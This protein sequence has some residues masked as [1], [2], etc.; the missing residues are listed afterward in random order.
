MYVLNAI[1]YVLNAI[2]YVLNAIA[3]GQLR[4]MAHFALSPLLRHCPPE[5]FS[6]AMSTE[7]ADL[8]ARVNGYA[9]SRWQQI[10]QSRATNDDHEIEQERALR[11]MTR[12][13]LTMASSMFGPPPNEGHNVCRAQH[14]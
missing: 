11:D 12:A 2:V 7:V 9:R 14:N 10:E 1:V 13:I 3:A 6:T 4:S 5:L 8:F